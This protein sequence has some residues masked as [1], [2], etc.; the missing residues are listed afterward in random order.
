MA[1]NLRAKLVEVMAAVPEI[2]K[3]GRSPGVSYGFV[4]APDVFEALRAPLIE[5]DVLLLASVTD[6]QQRTVERDGKD[7]IHVLHVRVRFEFFDGDSDERL[8][9]EGV[10]S[11]SAA[12]D[13]AELIA[14]TEAVKQGL[15]LAFLIPTRDEHSAAREPMPPR[16]AAGGVD[17]Q[18][19]EVFPISAAQLDLLTRRMKAKNL[20]EDKVLRHMRLQRLGDIAKRDFNGLLAWLEKE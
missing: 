18:T 20:P 3:L 1:K 9:F 17:R 11:A 7:N 2:R 15:L 6:V 8:I 13:K 4:Q 16:D 12:S 5:R 10:G 19:G 14:Y